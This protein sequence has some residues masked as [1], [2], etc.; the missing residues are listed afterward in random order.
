MTFILARPFLETLYRD[1]IT[2]LHPGESVR[3]GL[4]AI[5]GAHPPGAP[6]HILAIGKAAATMSHAALRWI[7]AH[8]AVS[9]AGGLSVAHAGN[10]LDL[11]PLLSVVGDHPTPGERSIEA[12]DAVDE[13]IREHVRAGDHV[14]VLLSGGASALI[15]APRDPMTLSE[16]AATC[17]A[18]LGS[19]LSINQINRQRRQLSRWGGGRLGAALQA[20]GASVQVLVISDVIGDEL[21]AIGS[22]PC[23]P[24]TGNGRPPIAHHVLLSNQTARGIVTAL[25]RE[26]GALAVAVDDPL[27][28]DVQLCAERITLALLTHASQARLG[29]ATNAP[30]VIC[31]GG[32]PTITLPA[33]NPPPG[34]RMQA[35]AMSIARLLHDAG[36]DA[37]GIT[38]LAA[39]TDG[40]DGPTDAAGAIIDSHTW[41]AMR[42]SGRTPEDD[43]STFHSH[44]ALAA[45]RALIPAFVSGTNVN[46]LVIALVGERTYRQGASARSALPALTS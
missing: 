43:L 30:R 33:T 22:G 10:E 32:E 20:R 21:S 4:A 23:V 44:D 24:D 12:A 13:Y 34:G 36:D 40:R 18:L 1:T 29:G 2:A 46:D 28:G 38:I 41:D 17:N 26:R 7:D 6:L 16:F 39:G 19:G 37:A 5:W 45:V 25:A 3:S 9:V 11:A 15:G 27:H 8:P 42:K 14:L 31:W 35:L